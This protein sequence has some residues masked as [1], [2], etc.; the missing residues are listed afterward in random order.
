[1]TYD[2]LQEA[3][4][5]TANRA[6]DAGFKARV[7][8]L[9][10]LAEA[11]MMRRI[12][13]RG[14]TQTMDIEVDGDTYPLPCGFDGIV[15]INGTG[16]GVREIQ[17]VSADVLDRVRWPVVNGYTI[18][19]DSL[20]FSRSPGSIRLRYR[21]MFCPLSSRNRSNWLQNKHPDAYLY[22]TLKHA[23]PWLED[24]ERMP[25]WMRLFDDAIDTINAQALKQMFGGPLIIQSD[26][27]DGGHRRYLGTVQTIQE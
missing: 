17:Y 11:E 16:G 23:A 7:P 8:G 24:D 21:A 13:A 12:R 27:V 26:R 18:S 20:Y 22:G 19:G 3:V 9:I 1:M 15:S 2:E 6:T 5:Q 14:E 25:T 10:Q 4:W